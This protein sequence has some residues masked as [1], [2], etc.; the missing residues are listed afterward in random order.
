MIEAQKAYSCD[1]HSYNAG[2]GT[3]PEVQVEA[4]GDWKMMI[5]LDACIAETIQELWKRGVMTEGSCCGHGKIKPS[6]VVS[7]DADMEEC[8]KILDEIDPRDWEISQWQR[9]VYEDKCDE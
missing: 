1:C 6:V 2:W 5:C 9:I 7:Q 4:P 3:I 8:Q